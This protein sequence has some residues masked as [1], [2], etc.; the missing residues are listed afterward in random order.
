MSVIEDALTWF[1]IIRK[2]EAVILSVLAELELLRVVAGIVVNR[3]NHRAVI[4]NKPIRR[5]QSVLQSD[6]AIFG[7]GRLM[8]RPPQKVQGHQGFEDRVVSVWRARGS[9]V[10]GRVKHMP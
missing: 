9:Q 6:I 4:P 8:A 1:R 2:Y 5:A 10:R 3:L 7:I